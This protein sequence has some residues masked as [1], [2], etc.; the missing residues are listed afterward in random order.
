MTSII[1]A[2]GSPRP[3]AKRLAEYFSAMQPAELVERQ[4]AVDST[5]VNMGIRFTI[6]PEGDNI[7][8]A[9]PLDIIPRA[10]SGFEWDRVEHGLIQ[11][12]KALN[13]FID[14][15]YNERRILKDKII[16]AEIIDSSKNY[17][18]P[19]RG[20][21]P[22]HGVWV[23]ICG[24]DHVRDRDVTIYVLEDK[25]RVPSGVSYMLENRNVIKRV[26][27][28]IFLNHRDRHFD[29]LSAPR[30]RADQLMGDHGSTLINPIIWCVLNSFWL[31]NN[32]DVKILS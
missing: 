32:S 1:D 16:P 6:Y 14:N 26:F 9:W 31:S 17:L 18:A 12:V 21:K 22:R 23:Y 4:R 27:P 2:N 28:S 5:I 13:L 20:A 30:S 3:H 24:S 11:R 7:D 19:C 10:M 25:L 8:R 15:L 29:A